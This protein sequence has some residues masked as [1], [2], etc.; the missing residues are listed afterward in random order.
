MEDLNYKYILVAVLAL[1]GLAAFF[2]SSDRSRNGF[3]LFI[4]TLGLGF[5]TVAIHGDLRVHPAEIALFLTW[6][7]TLGQRR[8]AGNRPAGPALPRWL[9]LL[10][11]FMALAWLQAD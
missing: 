3:L 7:L 1:A 9:W 4:A 11:P 2:L 6:L 10:L 8:A 5:R